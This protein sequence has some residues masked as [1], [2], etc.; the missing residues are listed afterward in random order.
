MTSL[1]VEI[2]EQIFYPLTSSKVYPFLFDRLTN[3]AARETLWRHMNITDIQPR[4]TSFAKLYRRLTI[5]PCSAVLALKGTRSLRLSI[6]GL[7]GAC[8][9]RL[10][11]AMHT[12]HSVE[13]LL[14]GDELD[15]SGALLLPASVRHVTTNA[16]KLL[17][18]VHDEDVG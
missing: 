13:L 8:H 9:I 12:L 18:W 14:C 3:K 6:Q 7:V 11:E 1:P 17:W 5:D 10:V 4:S 16:P 15:G 2:Q